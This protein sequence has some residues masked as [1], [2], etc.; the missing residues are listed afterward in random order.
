MKRTAIAFLITVFLVIIGLY[1]TYYQNPFI[2]G[3]VQIAAKRDNILTDEAFLA[4]LGTYIDD[5][6]IW[7]LLNIKQLIAWLGIWSGVIIGIIATFHLFFD[8][9]FFRKF[10]EEPDILLA[11][12]R[13]AYLA[14]TL[15]GA[16]FLRLINGLFWYN[17]TSIAL[18]FLF[19]EI[20]LL[21]ISKERKET[22]THQVNQIKK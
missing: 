14:L 6:L 17:I 16:I 5:G 2:L 8:K 4:H 15:L 7:Q 19:I 18:L 3:Q 22:K 20:L 1:I 9:L 12:R 11:V 13:G 21:S 10:Y